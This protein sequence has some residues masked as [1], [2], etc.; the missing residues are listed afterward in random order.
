MAVAQAELKRV[1]GILPKRTLFNVASFDSKVSL[2][3]KSEAE[4]DD[5]TIASAIRWAAKQ[6]SKRGAFTNTFEVLERTLLQNPRI[7]TIYL[8]SDGIPE[9]GDIISREGLLAA[10]RDWNRFR[11][12]TINT[13]AI[14]HLSLNPGKYARKSSMRRAEVFMR[15]LAAAGGGTYRFVSRPQ[16]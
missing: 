16:K 6:E 8:L 1:L 14:T 13:F 11:R 10:V 9:W 15:D 12:V 2:W 7:D 4:A 5:K 3:R